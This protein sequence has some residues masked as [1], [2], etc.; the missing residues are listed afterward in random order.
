MAWSSW[1]PARSIVT[2]SID[3]MV[4][5]DRM[6]SRSHCRGLARIPTG[7]TYSSPH[8][9][10]RRQAIGTCSAF[11]SRSATRPGP[12]WSGATGACQDSDHQL[13]VWAKIS[14]DRERARSEVIR[15]FWVLRA[16]AV[17]AGELTGLG[18]D[19]FFL[20]KAEIVRVL[21]GET[22]S[23]TLINRRRAA[24]QAYSALPK[25]PALIRGTFNP[26]AWAADPNRRSDIFIE[27]T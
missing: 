1:S 14:R 17:R 3:A 19:I 15:Y 23:S 22:I 27:G 8:A 11:R 18:D 21:Q 9:R 25:Y 5:A 7:S 20:D 4:T 16:Y 6:S 2:R 10:H 13:R 12:S 26:Y 24:Y